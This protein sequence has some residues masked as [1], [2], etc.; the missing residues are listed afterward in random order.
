MKN[1]PLCNIFLLFTSGT[2]GRVMAMTDE[3][4]RGYVAGLIVGEGSFSGSATH[5]RLSMKQRS[6]LPPLEAC[7]DLLGGRIHGPYSHTGKDGT[8]RVYHMWCLDG[9]SLIAAM[10][11]LGEIL[12]SSN[13]RTQFESWR[14]SYG[15]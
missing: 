6:N 15:I 9:S 5:P 2:Y 8:A 3:F 7:R 14:L 1:I 13:K 4:L 10:P 11:T 12:P